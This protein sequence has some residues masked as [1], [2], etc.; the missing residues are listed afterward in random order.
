MVFQNVSISFADLFFTSKN[1]TNLYYFYFLHVISLTL[2]TLILK[3]S[4]KK[5]KKSLTRRKSDF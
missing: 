5:E 4:L 1:T 2:T 3:F